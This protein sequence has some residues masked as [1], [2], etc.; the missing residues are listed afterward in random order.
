M[1]GEVD[2]WTE[3]LFL[4][5]LATE[6]SLHWINLSASWIQIFLLAA[7][8]QMEIAAFP[9]EATNRVHTT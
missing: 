3:F 9:A 4:H 7:P 8:T 2:L 6:L 5:S 1:L